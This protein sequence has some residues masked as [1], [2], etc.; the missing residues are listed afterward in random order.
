[1]L[2]LV[3]DPLLLVIVLLEVVGKL[4][5]PPGTV[6]VVELVVYLIPLGLL[7]VLWVMLSL[8]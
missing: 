1:M 3:V 7:L 2:V 4:M 8:L 5:A 6:G